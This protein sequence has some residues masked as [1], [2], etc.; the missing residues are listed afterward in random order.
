[1]IVLLRLGDA[2]VIVH[3]IEE[4]L[5]RQRDVFLPPVVVGDVKHRFVRR[6]LERGA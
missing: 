5:L 4:R 3:D 6:A 1:M 2:E